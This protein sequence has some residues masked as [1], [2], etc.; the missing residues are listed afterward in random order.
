MPKAA[1]SGLTA[2]TIN[3]GSISRDIRISSPSWLMNSPGYLTRVGQR[4]LQA[5]LQQFQ[6]HEL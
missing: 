2:S 3:A 1:S 6:L 5:R 4:R